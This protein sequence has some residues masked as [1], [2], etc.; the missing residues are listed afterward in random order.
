MEISEEILFLHPLG[1]MEDSE[2]DKY[3]FGLVPVKLSPFIKSLKSGKTFIVSWNDLFE[4]AI[5]TGI[6]ECSD[7]GKNHPNPFR[8]D[9]SDQ[10]EKG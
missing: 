6:A 8:L 7:N 4:I 5:A 1:E 3:Q 2:G 10:T 9:L